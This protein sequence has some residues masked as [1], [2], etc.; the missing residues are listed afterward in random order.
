MNTSAATTPTKSAA[1]ASIESMKRSANLV[2]TRLP[3]RALL[4]LAAP[5]RRR[6]RHCRRRPLETDAARSVRRLVLGQRLL[7][8]L[9][10]GVRI[11]A[12]LADVVGPLLLQRLARLPPPA[13]LGVGYGGNRAAGAR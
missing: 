5:S 6:R 2:V 7:E 13:A 4:L 1:I 11:A 8:L 12:G 10:D 9:H 3:P